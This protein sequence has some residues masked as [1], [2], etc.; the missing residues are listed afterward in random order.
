MS[1]YRE[2]GDPTKKVAQPCLSCKWVKLRTLLL[3]RSQLNWQHAIRALTSGVLEHYPTLSVSSQA[4]AMQRDHVYNFA[5]L[6]TA[7][8]SLGFVCDNCREGGKNRSDAVLSFWVVK[9]EFCWSEL[10]LSSAVQKDLS[11]APAIH[12]RQFAVE[13]HNTLRFGAKLP[14]LRYCRNFHCLRSV[15]EII[16]GWNFDIVP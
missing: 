14:S 4:L 9:L 11:S 12:H 13:I 3:P 2:N 6:M 10:Q 16:L 8:R 5:C 15:S 7:C 1:I